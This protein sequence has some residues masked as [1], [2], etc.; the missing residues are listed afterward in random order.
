M[1]DDFSSLR[2]MKY[3]GRG[4]TLGM[5]PEGSYFIGYSLTGR[6][7]S[8]QARKLV[9]DE[10]SMVVRTE[11]TD[12]EQL[13]KGNPALLIYPAV[14]FAGGLIVASNG[15]QTRLLMNSARKVKQPRHVIVDAFSNPVIEGGIDITS[16][17]PDAPNYTPRISCCVDISEGE[18]HIVKRDE[19][20]ESHPL[21]GRFSLRQ[22]RARLITTYKGGNENP[23]LPFEGNAHPVSIDS[24]SAGEI[25]RSIYDSIGPK[26]GTNYR[27]AAAVM[28]VKKSGLETVVMNRAELGE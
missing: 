26:D 5:T 25:C 8:S 11:V 14:A 7:P 22:G 15:A 9:Y 17:E 28:M 18:I 4:I 23:L 10:K 16:Y 1:T 2:D 19:N 12:K 24:N 27:V 13:A 3:S 20:G 21:W 6:S